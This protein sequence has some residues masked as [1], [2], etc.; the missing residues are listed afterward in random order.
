MVEEI[1][2]F[3]IFSRTLKFMQKDVIKKMFAEH[4]GFTAIQKELQK[5]FGEQAYK[6]ST[7]Y[8][9]MQGEKLGFSPE[10]E[11][12][13]HEN[14][15]DEQLLYTIRRVIEESEFFSVRSVAQRLR[16]NETIVY[17]YFTRELHLVYKHTKW[18]PHNLDSDLKKRRANIS[19]ELF[20]VLQ[21]SQHTGYRNII[22]GDQ[23]WF[24]YRYPPHGAWVLHDEKAPVF[25]NDHFQAEKMMITVIWG[26]YGT[27][28]INE[29]PEGETLDSTYFVNNILI[30]LETQ[31]DL[32]WPNRQR[33]KIW[34][35]LDN[36]RVHNSKYTQGEI[37]NYGF[38][39]APHPPY[40]PDLAPSDFFLFGY[41]KDKLLGQHYTDRAPL[42]EEIKRIISG[43]PR[44]IRLNVF[45][46]WMDRCL[47]VANHEGSYYQ[48]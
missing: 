16:V 41:V 31:K 30:P 15:I 26:V 40:S 19:S 46:A 1:F 17:R 35:H 2:F 45:N 11:I 29:L 9:V 24:L 13:P 4:Q 18:I 10:K 7:I 22:T 44:Q 14:K 21:K 34:L 36:C 3:G 8:Q 5:Q 37:R 43:I 27:Y 39:R 48:K 32:I 47:W 6:R 28:I 25:A 42:L 23:S 20:E 38:K 12:S 33:H